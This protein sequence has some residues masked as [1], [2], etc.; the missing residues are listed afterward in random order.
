MKVTF[1]KLEG[2]FINGL[3]GRKNKS[4]IIA[5]DSNGRVGYLPDSDTP[6]MPVGGVKTLKS[7]INI[8]VFR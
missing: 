4:A 2:S 1:K 7:V 6:Y 3:S 8:L 5:V